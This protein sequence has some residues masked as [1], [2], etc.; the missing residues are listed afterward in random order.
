M[1]NRF[2]TLAVRL[3]RKEGVGPW[4]RG[5]GDICTDT[6]GTRQGLS[7]REKVVVLAD[8]ACNGDQGPPNRGIHEIEPSGVLSE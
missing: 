2:S 1:W 7:G 3:L 4:Y 8:E 5:T 6:A